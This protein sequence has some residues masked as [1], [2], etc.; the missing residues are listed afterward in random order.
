MHRSGDATV[1]PDRLFEAT[2]VRLTPRILRWFNFACRGQIW[3]A[4]N[5]VIERSGRCDPEWLEHPFEWVE[6]KQLV[7]DGGSKK[8]AGMR[9]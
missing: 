8:V 5:D 3:T 2:R 1:E 9:G 7:N 6:R 4:I